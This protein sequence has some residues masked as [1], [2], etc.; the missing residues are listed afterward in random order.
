MLHVIR[1]NAVNTCT[2]YTYACGFVVSIYTTVVQ[3]MLHKIKHT[4]TKLNKPHVYMKYI[5]NLFVT[6]V[7]HVKCS[8]FV[9]AMTVYIFLEIMR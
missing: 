1:K 7:T 4:T 2:D 6:T 9:I 3:I 5:N 8:G